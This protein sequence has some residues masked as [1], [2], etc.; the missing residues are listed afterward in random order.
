MMGA[1]QAMMADHLEIMEGNL[2]IMEDDQKCQNI[3]NWKSPLK[4]YKSCR[5]T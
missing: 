5:I 1:H 2:E 3:P 4:T